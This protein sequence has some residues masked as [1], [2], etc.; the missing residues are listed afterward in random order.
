MV[1]LPILGL[2]SLWTALI[3]APGNDLDRGVSYGNF[4]PCPEKPGGCAPC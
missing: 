3:G 4:I 1:Q 2:P